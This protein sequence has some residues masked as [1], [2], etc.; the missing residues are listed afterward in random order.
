MITILNLIK[1]K[2][3]MKK[4]K[5]FMMLI[6]FLSAQPLFVACGGDD[7]ATDSGNQ[8]VTIGD[9]GKASNGSVFSSIDDKNF[10]LDY[11]KYTV[12]EGHLAVSG[13]DKSGFKGVANI[14]SSITYKGNFYEVLEI[15][16]KAFN[17]CDGLISVSIPTCV[18]KIGSYAFG[19]C[20]NLT[21]MDIKDLSAWC[22]ISFYNYASNPLLFVHHLYV[23]GKEVKELII[24]SDITKINSYSFT[25]CSYLN[26]IRIHKNVTSVG[27]A[28]SYC[29]GLSSITVEEGNP[30]YDSRNNC[31]AIIQTSTKTLVTGCSKTII[32]NDITSIA[33]DAFKGCEGLES[34]TIPSS[35]TSIGYETFSGCKGLTSL[36]IEDGTQELGLDNSGLSG[37]PL[38]TLY[39]GRN[40]SFQSGDP[41]YSPFSN[42][43]NLSSLTFGSGVT[44]IPRYTFSGCNSLISLTIPQNVK[45]INGTAF[46][47]CSGLTS[48]HCLSSIPPE[49]PNEYW[50]LAFYSGIYYGD[51]TNAAYKKA[52]LYVPKGS[53]EAYKSKYEWGL[54]ENIVEE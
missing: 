15:S 11:I 31:N 36:R 5:S 42:K 17:N 14:V 39:M 6:L 16:D 28:F 53:I 25:G 7:D 20:Y 10:Y 40:V 8:Q 1:T 33:S 46:E 34:L 13:Y 54:F 24:P 41:S 51:E 30:N 32:P 3:I 4:L 18:T 47:Q 12:K 43:K 19:G 44:S 29:G 49:T 27:A 35:V 9:D 52:T 50:N 37:C 22:K 21:S 48:I 23:N 38:T 26:T 2:T 45:Y